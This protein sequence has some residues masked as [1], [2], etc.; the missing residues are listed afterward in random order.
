MKTFSRIIINVED[1]IAPAVAA[2]RVASVVGE[3]RVS[4]NGECYCY[5]TTFT[6][7]AAVYAVRR[8]SGTDVFYVRKDRRE[9]V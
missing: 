6:D 3:G 5:A 7:G 2:Y 9:T 4:G 8:K 1:D